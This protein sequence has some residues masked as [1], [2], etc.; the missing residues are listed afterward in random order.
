M[1]LMLQ[2]NSDNLKETFIIKYF[3]FYNESGHKVFPRVNL[4]I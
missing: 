2:L 3:Q 4:M 1:N